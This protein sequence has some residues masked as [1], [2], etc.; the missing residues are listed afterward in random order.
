MAWFGSV[1]VVTGAHDD[2][3]SEGA[4]IGCHK[5]LESCGFTLDS[6]NTKAPAAP[7]TLTPGRL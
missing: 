4:H 7:R 3:Q 2:H 1:A 5:T 6:P